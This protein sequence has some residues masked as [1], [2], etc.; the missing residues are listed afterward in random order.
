MNRREYLGAAAGAVAGAAL[1]ENMAAGQTRRPRWP[2]KPPPSSSLAC[3]P[4]GALIHRL[5]GSL[6]FSEGRKIKG[7]LEESV[8]TAWLVL[9]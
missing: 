6:L 1:L 7:L 5:F 4:T 3:A 9:S 8:P 2:T